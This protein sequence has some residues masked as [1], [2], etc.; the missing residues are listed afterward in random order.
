MGRA[1]STA[2][3]T[4]RI[5][6]VGCGALVPNVDGS[7]FRYPDAASP[8]CWAIQSESLADA[9]GAPWTPIALNLAVDAYAVQHPCRVTPQT[10]QSGIVHLISLCCMLERGQGAGH[11]TAVMRRA[12]RRDRRA[13]EWLSPLGL[14][15]AV[16][17]RGVVGAGISAERETRAHDWASSVRAAWSD[18]H[19]RI[20]D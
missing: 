19:Q 2:R 13:F 9:H 3:A 5:P 1:P 18:H 4:E 20:R 7:T 11:A 10:K 8:E 17:E 6:C 12:I 16:T 14:G 15:G